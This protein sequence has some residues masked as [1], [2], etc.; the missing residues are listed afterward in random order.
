MRCNYVYVTEFWKI[1]H[2]VAPETI[3]IFEFSMP[4]LIAETAFKN[5]SKLC[6]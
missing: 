1:T 4:L 2:M 5:I 6:L 3:G